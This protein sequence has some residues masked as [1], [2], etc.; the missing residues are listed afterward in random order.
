[1]TDKK[2]KEN[3]CHDTYCCVQYTNGYLV[4]GMQNRVFDKSLI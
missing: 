4:M 3:L 1:M 2:G